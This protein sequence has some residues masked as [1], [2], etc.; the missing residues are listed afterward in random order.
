M[1]LNLIV[2]SAAFLFAA[3]ASHATP[4]ESERYADWAHAKSESLLRAAGVAADT[5]PVSVRASVSL[6]GKITGI[7]VLH[8]SGSRDT[9]AAV[10]AVLEK[11]IRSKPPSGLVDGAV[12]LNVG[13]GAI[14]QADAH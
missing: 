5:Q 8:S 10:V 11:I 4:S 2:L 7:R 12:T 14:V 1:K 3:S 13:E 9:D 6:G